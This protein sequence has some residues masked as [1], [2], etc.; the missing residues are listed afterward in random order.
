MAA[1]PPPA[2]KIR[3]DALSLEQAD[4]IVEVLSP[5]V[6]E[7]R[8]DR[9]ERALAARTRDLVVVLEDIHS[10]HNASAVLRSAEAFGLVEVHAVPRTSEFKLSRK[11]SL[12]THKW[13]DLRRGARAAETYA[14]LA[15]RGYQ[16][17]AAD[18]HGDP[19]PLQQIPADRPVALVFGNEHEGLT[20]EAVEA[21]DGVFKIPMTGFVESLNISVAAAVAMHDQ[22]ERRRALGGPAPLGPDELRRIRA[23]WYALSVRAAPQLLGR[24]DLPRPF[25]SLGPV[26][27]Y[28]RHPEGGTIETVPVDEDR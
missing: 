10:D 15:A 1:T 27:Y 5:Y 19:V 2:E 12:G 25:M 7:A 11:V 24:A 4:R 26:R 8:G 17:W 28:H 23:A 21:A 9:I 18:V 22:L 13:L 16:I 6:S 20:R 3:Y 14:G